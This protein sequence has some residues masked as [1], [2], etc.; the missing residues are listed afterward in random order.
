MQVHLPVG[1]KPVYLP[2]IAVVGL[3]YVGLPVAVAMS[4][5]F[6]VMGY[7][8][9]VDRIT[10]LKSGKDRTDEVSP[11]E[12][13]LY[14]GLFTYN[15]ADIRGLDIYIVA[16]PT[17]ITKNNQPAL[18]PLMRAC[19][20]VGK[21]MAPGALVIFES[22]VYPGCTEEDCIP[23]LEKASGLKHG[24]HFTVG[25]SP[26]RIN[27][28]DKVHRFETIKKVVS[29]CCPEAMNKVAYIYTG[30][31]QAGV[32]EAASIKVAEAAKIIENTQRDVNVALINELAMICDRI[33]IDTKDVLDAAATKWNFLKFTPGLVGGHCIGVDPYYLIAKARA[34]GYESKVITSGR[35]VNDGMGAFIAQKAINEYE[36]A[37]KRPP[38]T[39]QIK[40]AILGFTFKENCPD[41]RNTKVLDVIRRL[42]EKRSEERRVGK[43]GRS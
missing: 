25:Y 15:Y 34:L 13:R 26:E 36:K 33:G 32:Y 3:G 38:I 12:L 16:V 31:V 23:A 18:N 4:R 6:P 30:A 43:E 20:T 2:T 9:N 8:I 7:D 37:A 22:T 11:E 10:E 29:A 41:I 39:G 28:G 21:A 42:E 35:A 24:K 27:P 19:E 1:I 14:Q 17:P 40:A 5:K